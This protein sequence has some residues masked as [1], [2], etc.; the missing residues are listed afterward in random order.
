MVES[1]SERQES[2]LKMNCL[3]PF[4]RL[5]EV[6]TGRYEHMTMLVWLWKVLKISSYGYP[7]L[8]KSL[9]LLRRTWMRK[10]KISKQEFYRE[11]K[12]TFIQITRGIEAFSA[13]SNQSTVVEELLH[14]PN[15]HNKKRTTG[16]R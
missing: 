11:N 10:S 9:N 5:K 8:K 6:K 14:R 4:V 3:K 12:V 1:F 16:S 15:L 2:N 13:R 7:G